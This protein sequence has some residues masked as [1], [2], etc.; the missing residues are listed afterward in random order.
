MNEFYSSANVL[1][2]SSIICKTHK[3]SICFY[4]SSITFYEGYVGTP[5]K[6]TDADSHE[7]SFGYIG[8]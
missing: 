8:I 6:E 5:N 4:H 2:Y 3:K 1:I 7:R